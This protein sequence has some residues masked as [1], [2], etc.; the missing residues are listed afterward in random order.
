[1]LHRSVKIQNIA[2]SENHKH[3]CIKESHNVKK[4]RKKKILWMNN[5]QDQ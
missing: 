4:E 3:W 1:M 5:S 2:N